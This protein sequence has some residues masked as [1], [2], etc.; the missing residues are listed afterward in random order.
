MP[1]LS[2]SAPLK[3]FRL[4]PTGDLG[5]LMRYW[6][7]LR[8]RN[9]LQLSLETGFSQKQISFWENGRSTPGRDTLMCICEALDVP[10]RERNQ[11]FVA[12][13]YAPVYSDVPWN[14][15]EVNS[16]TNATRRIL[17][18]HEPFPA[19]V[20]DRYWKVV[21]T[22]DAAPRF[23]GKFFDLSSRKGPRNMLH[24]IFDPAGMRPFVQDWEIAAKSLLQR[25][26]REAT[27]GVRDPKTHELLRA[28]LSYPGVREGWKKPSV[29][30]VDSVSAGHPVIPLSFRREGKILRYFS[31]VTVVGTA[32]TV[33]AQELRIETM[34]P[35]DQATETLH[36]KLME[37]P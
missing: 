14:A 15:D 3:P 22:N 1:S 8:A 32:Q 30:D 23:F 6:R 7:E 27:G 36:Q 13:G 11:L 20:M 4:P 12:A 17:R 26:Y 34:F 31:M 35:V 16:I 18:Q 10:L 19:L 21:M 25:V 24:L 2:T 29:F 5:E 28:L 9:Q 37:I 33:A